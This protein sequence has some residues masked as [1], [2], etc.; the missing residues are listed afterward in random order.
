MVFG[1][2]FSPVRSE[3]AALVTR[4]TLFLLRTISL[5]ASATEE[6][7]TSTI[8]STL[9]VSIHVRA[10]FDPTSGLF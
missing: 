2:H 9:S 6:V 5:T 8:T 4:N 7:G 1:V 10:M 3:V